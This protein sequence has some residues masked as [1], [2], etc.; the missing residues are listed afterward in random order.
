[1]A[2]WRVVDLDCT[3]YAGVVGPVID[4]ARCD[5]KAGCVEV[6]PNDVF[7]IGRITDEDFRGLSL[8]AKLNSLV[9]GKMTAYTP[10]ADACRACGKCVKACPERAI[11]LARR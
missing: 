9:H 3:E 6:C 2:T 1:M 4:R 8:L 7:A 5:G 10:A 11:H